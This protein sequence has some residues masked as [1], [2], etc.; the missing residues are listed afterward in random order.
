MNHV[1]DW[2]EAT[3]AKQLALMSALPMAREAVERE[4]H[5]QGYTSAI[6]LVRQPVRRC[7]ICISI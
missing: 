4:H 3:A 2:F 6:N 7:S 5:P 1:A